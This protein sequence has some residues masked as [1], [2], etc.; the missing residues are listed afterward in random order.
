MIVDLQEHVLKRLPRNARAGTARLL[1]RYFA[2][3]FADDVTIFAKDADLP[4]EVLSRLYANPPPGD[5]E[6]TVSLNHLRVIVDDLPNVQWLS[7]QDSSLLRVDEYMCEWAA[8]AGSLKVLKWL[9]EQDPPCSWGEET[10]RLAVESGDPEV[11]MWLRTQDPPCPWRYDDMCD[12]AAYEGQMEVLKWL[13]AQDPPCPWDAKTCTSAARTGRLEVLKW[14]RA[15][16]PP[17]P[18]DE[19]TCFCAAQRLNPEVL[20]WL[21]AQDPPCPWDRYAI[22]QQDRLTDR[23]WILAQV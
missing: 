3:L 13:R 6:F 11:L 19:E 18:W 5:G 7:A 10:C 21:R 20:R 12:E 22:L 8:S 2:T 15:Q 17:C 1:S 4:N 9:R 16:D 14:L 23:A